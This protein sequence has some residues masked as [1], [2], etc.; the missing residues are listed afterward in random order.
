MLYLLFYNYIG[1]QRDICFQLCN[2]I[3]ESQALIRAG[4]FP[5]T[6]EHPRLAF[7]VELLD[8]LEAL[9]LEC[10]VPVKDFVAALQYLHGSFADHTKVQH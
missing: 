1:I 8:L 3:S 4:F 10:Q 5:A 2:C 7:A 6:P 9:L